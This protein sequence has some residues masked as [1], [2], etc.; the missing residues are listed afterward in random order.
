MRDFNFTFAENETPKI[1]AKITRDLNVIID[2][3][4]RELPYATIVLG[5]SFSFGE[6]NAREEGDTIV[7]CSDYD[8]YV[9]VKSLPHAVSALRKK[10]LRNLSVTLSPGIGF[11]V[12]LTIIWQTLIALNL[13]WISGRMLE[14]NPEV[15]KLMA[16]ATISRKKLRVS[17]LKKAYLF[18]LEAV[19]ENAPG[20]HHVRDAL[21]QGFRSF[22][23]LK[24]RNEEIRASWRKYYSLRYNL[25]MLNKY[26]G[27]LKPDLSECIR[28]AITSKLHPGKRPFEVTPTTYGLTKEF[29]GTLFFATKRTF[30]WQDYLMY[31]LYQ[32][33]HSKAPN[34]LLDPNR[35]MLRA[36]YHLSNAIQEDGILDSRELEKAIK[37]L[38]QVTGPQD[39]VEDWIRFAWCREKIRL[40]GSLYL[41]K[42]G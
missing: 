28:S 21:I 14:G 2:W 4:R 33:M 40:L 6:G 38:R 35:V 18:L 19:Q 42:V 23:G 8:I 3:I 22:L 32:L 9:I 16:K 24:E 36:C 25:S 39:F 37:T 29:L 17:H 26:S 41:H 15:A 27:D 30:L 1:R 11:H 7:T 5:G 13:T 12:D 31:V 10:A 20:V 34:F